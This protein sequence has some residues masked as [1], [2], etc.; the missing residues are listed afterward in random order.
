MMKEHSFSVQLT[1]REHV[2]NVCLGDGSEILLEGYLGH[3]ET[4][5]LVDESIIEIRGSKGVLR[6]DLTKQQLRELLTKGEEAT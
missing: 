5:E 6:F 2:K 1:S 4:L 3:L